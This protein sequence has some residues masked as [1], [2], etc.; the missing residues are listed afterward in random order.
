MNRLTL[1][2]FILALL[3]SG[4][5]SSTVDVQMHPGG[6]VNRISRTDM[7]SEGGRLAIVSDVKHVDPLGRVHRRMTT[8]IIFSLQKPLPVGNPIPQP[9]SKF[10]L[11]DL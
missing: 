11:E 2:N 8:K 6:W 7:A 9:R 4:C 1:L 3:V 10:I 5:V